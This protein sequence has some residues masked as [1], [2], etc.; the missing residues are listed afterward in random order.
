MLSKTMFEIQASDLLKICSLSYVDL[1]VTKKFSN[2]I[3]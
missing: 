2:V 1:V 3:C